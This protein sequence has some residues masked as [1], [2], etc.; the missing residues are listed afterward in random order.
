MKKVFILLSVIFSHLAFAQ[1]PIPAKPQTKS[2]LF[3]G[4]MVHIGNGQTIEL[5]AVGIKDGKI[6]FVQDANQ[7]RVNP[8]GWD[9]VINLAGKHLYPGFI[10]PNATLGL[11]EVSAVRATN[12]LGDVGIYNPHIRSIIGYNTDSK[13]PPTVRTNGV[14]TAEITPRKGVISG[15]SS[16]VE[17]DGWNW[18]DAALK[19]DMGIH[20][21]FPRL[22][23]RNFE[24]GAG[25]KIEVDKDY[26]KKINELAKFFAEAKAYSHTEKPEEKNL[27][28]EAMKGL[29]NG[30]KILF[31]HA[32]YVKDIM[33]AVNFAKAQGV[34]KTVLVGGAD[35]PK[36]AEFL[37]SNNIAVIVGRV[38]DLPE[39]TDED[40]DQH[41]KLPAQLQQAGIL[42]CLNNQGDMEQANTRNLPFQAGTAA[43]YGLTKEQAVASISGNAA[44]I[45]GVDNRIGTIEV[46]KDATI[47]IS[48][49][50]ALDMR[51]N[52]IEQAY[53]R[54]KKLDLVNHQEKLYNIYKEKYNIK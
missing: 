2:I 28:F 43:T 52:N 20:L 14:L 38:H 24:H 46:G 36:V 4:A 29:F 42:F 32:E 50:D 37:K 35:A 45:L 18:E 40:I 34:T 41:Y 3:T 51:T 23:K 5:G 49:G 11:I 10:A 53:I 54:G 13:I 25:G 26:S 7:Y 21:N 6:T 16:V 48:S 9:T 12:D 31:V 22:L 8:S 33:A 44:K 1:N 47:F 19:M 17:L 27:R 30:S 15:T 39:N